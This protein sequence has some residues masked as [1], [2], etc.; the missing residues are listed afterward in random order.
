MKQMK[1]W[2][3]LCVAMTICACTLVGALSVKA[4]TTP[5]AMSLDTDGKATVIPGEEVNVAIRVSGIP[6]EGWDALT[7][8]LVYPA[9]QLELVEASQGPALG[10][11]IAMV[12]TRQNPMVISA[13]S[14][15]PIANNGALYSFRFCVKADVS[16]GQTIRTQLMI[17]ECK[18]SV[19]NGS[20]VA[21]VDVISPQVVVCDVAIPQ[22]SG[23]HVSRMP[24]RINYRVGMPLDLNGMIVTAMY[25][26]GAA[27]TVPVDQL[28][29]I[30]F[31][32]A[33]AGR[34]QVTIRYQG[35]SLA[36]ITIK[37]RPF[38]YGDL[39]G[40]DRV[41]SMDA[42]AI[43][44]HEAGLSKIEDDKLVLADTNGDTEVN[45]M[46]ALHILQY[47]AG[48]IPELSVEQEI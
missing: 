33:K 45:S 27:A 22:L 40:D 43:L 47:E 39:D 15:A 18:R 14:L 26:N 5:A 9:D 42:L 34:Q 11:A 35:W 20:S 24:H 3:A 17:E 21:F 6:K 10:N 13:I 28:D 7:V 4:E 44:A 46:D 48:I 8:K 19:P 16:P 38:L 36:P 12:N 41:D 29:A 31:D 25:S 23:L 37:V 2:L 30:G 32:G 1:K